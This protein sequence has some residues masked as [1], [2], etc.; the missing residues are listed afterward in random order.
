VPVVDRGIKKTLAS[1]RSPGHQ[2]CSWLSEVW[3]AAWKVDEVDGKC[4]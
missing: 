1:C 4:M 2:A 3:E